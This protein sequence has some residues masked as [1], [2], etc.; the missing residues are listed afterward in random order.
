MVFATGA[1]TTGISAASSYYIAHTKPNE[2]PLEFSE[3]TRGHIRRVHKISGQAV[4]VSSKTTALIGECIDRAVG[5]LSGSSGRRSA[6]RPPSPSPVTAAH[7]S[8]RSPS[9][10]SPP[11]PPV[12]PPRNLNSYLTPPPRTVADGSTSPPLPPRPRLRNRVL[13]STDLLLTTLE[14]SAKHLVDHGSTK[15]G[16]ALGHK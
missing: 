4:S 13:L 2:K 11:S 9:P 10:M 14:N 3:S 6:S 7:G 1:V 8:S 16:E 12:L 5:Y 15:L